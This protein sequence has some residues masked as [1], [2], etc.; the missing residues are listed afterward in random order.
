MLMMNSNLQMNILI[1]VKWHIS[2]MDKCPYIAKLVDSNILL[3]KP[4][5]WIDYM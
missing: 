3:I 4:T 1:H 2:L 5:M